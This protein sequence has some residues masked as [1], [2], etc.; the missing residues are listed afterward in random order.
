MCQK[1]K[2]KQKTAIT[3]AFEPGLRCG[4]MG[5]QGQILHANGFFQHF[6]CQGVA[7]GYSMTTI[8]LKKS[9]MP[10]KNTADRSPQNHR[11]GSKT[12]TETNRKRPQGRHPK[13]QKRKPASAEQEKIGHRKTKQRK[14]TKGNTRSPRENKNR[15]ENGKEN[16]R[17]RRP[18]MT[19]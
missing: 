14:N 7:N 6:F 5:P 17:R 1:T 10:K 2:R 19:I 4:A 15:T 8:L 3:K 9:G 18:K 13:Q 16:F 11:T 12:A